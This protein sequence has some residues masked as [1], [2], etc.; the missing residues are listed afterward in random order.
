MATYMTEALLRQRMESKP[1]SLVFSRLAD[2]YR[3]SGNITQAIDLCTRGVL[4]HPE[5]VTG[6]IIL[7]RCYLEQE[8]LD[9]AAGAFV[10]VCRIDRRN[11]VALKM[12]ADIFIRRG[13]R[14]KAGD[15]Y[16]LLVRID[17]YNDLLARSANQTRGTGKKDLFDILGISYDTLP[18]ASERPAPDA[19]ATMIVDPQEFGIEPPPPAAAGQVDVKAPTELAGNVDVDRVIADAGEIT[20]SDIADRMTSMFGEE[21]KTEIVSV[22]EAAPE[23]PPEATAEEPAS[24]SIEV[25][26]LAE[27]PD[28]DTIT[29]RI[30]DLFGR[31]TLHMPPIKEVP[32]ETPPLVNEREAMVEELMP[33]HD[34]GMEETMILDAG[35]MK[36]IGEPGTPATP[37]EPAGILPEIDR[38]A[39]AQV[40]PVREGEAVS[41]GPELVSDAL[42]PVAEELFSDAGAGGDEELFTSFEK[43]PEQTAGDAAA[44]LIVPE[45]QGVDED[46]LSGNDVV[47]RLDRIFENKDNEAIVAAEPAAQTVEEKEPLAEPELIAGTGDDTHAVSDIED[48]VSGDDVVERIDEIFKKEIDL[49]DSFDTPEVPLDVPG[50]EVPGE[51]ILA[52]DSRE[53]EPEEPTAGDELLDG[54]FEQA[55]FEV[56]EVPAIDESL[57]TDAALIEIETPV[58]ALDETKESSRP[59]T[60]H[61]TISGDDVVERLEG[62][63]EGKEDNEAVTPEK[64]LVSF[65]TSAAAPK[66]ASEATIVFEPQPSTAPEADNGEVVDAALIEI[67]MSV[68]ALDET[69][70]YFRSDSI[71]GTISGDDVAERLEGIF[72]KKD[73][74]V[75]KDIPGDDRTATPPVDNTTIASESVIKTGESI[76]GSDVEQRLSEYFGEENTGKEKIDQPARPADKPDDL[77]IDQGVDSDDAFEETLISGDLD[78]LLIADAKKRSPAVSG[79]PYALPELLDENDQ[80][81]GVPPMAGESAGE[82]G[83]GPRDRV[84]AGKGDNLESTAVFEDFTPGSVPKAPPP[85]PD[86][87]L[88]LTET[89]ESADTG[90]V[91]DE[92]DKADLPGDLPDHVLTP[93]LADLYFQQGQAS[94]ALNIYRRLLAKNGD[95]EKIWKRVAEIEK[96]IAEG[97]TMPAPQKKPPAPSA[98]APKK[99]AAAVSR[100]SPR[101]KKRDSAVEDP[102]RPLSGVKLKKRP[103]IQW[104]KKSRGK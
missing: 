27:V 83:P 50:L 10:D 102:A 68:P 65:G 100:V 31:E 53:K 51:A 99:P 9:K 69:A 23:V 89:G 13:S 64:P 82:D 63:F 22:P 21:G 46:T 75:P 85:V 36:H 34:E 78:D 72:E 104:R 70:E 54:L 55:A 96:A 76:T 95:N 14:E 81:A 97:V 24:E 12:L 20:G 98:E 86:V 35:I 79:P 93:T 11:I 71:H 38:G 103:K 30:D 73:L 28:G 80:A 48:S 39:E 1:D 32:R 5:Y 16:A 74:Q 29:A 33:P 92:A 91:I 67:K 37:E 61:D 44:E 60:D 18:R 58:P 25:E 88:F 90:T 59:D 94:L 87:P 43:E 41:A 4:Q 40:P 45:A 7:G 42:E 19:S 101:P 77:S 57:P 8:N 17:P 26:P 3:K 84:S 56:V 15:L 52:I 2:L 6:R 49:Q 62:I 47:E 66:D